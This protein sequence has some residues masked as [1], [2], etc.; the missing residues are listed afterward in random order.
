MILVTGQQQ[1][2]TMLVTC[3][4]TR[5]VKFLKLYYC[6][7]AHKFIVMSK[8][9][10]TTISQDNNTRDWLQT[11]LYRV[12]MFQIV[13]PQ[14]ENRFASILLLAGYRAKGECFTKEAETFSKMLQIDVDILTY[15]ECKS[16]NEARD[17]LKS[18]FD[19]IASEKSVIYVGHGMGGRG[20]FC[21]DVGGD[22]VE[23]NI[24]E[25]SPE[26]IEKGKERYLFMH[27]FITIA[28]AQQKTRNVFFFNC[29]CYALAS[30]DVIGRWSYPKSNNITKFFVRSSGCEIKEL[31]AVK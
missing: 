9:P 24:N 18:F 20:S 21:F 3:I 10:P 22:N 31:I 2:Q 29:A 7:L 23:F 26:M 28:A 30:S 8:G 12:P 27:E 14:P 1:H 17:A 5:I 13:Q 25:N 16:A 15:A 6:F 19:G 4:H 11:E